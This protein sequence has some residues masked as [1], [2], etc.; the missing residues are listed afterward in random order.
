MASFKDAFEAVLLSPQLPSQKT[1]NSNCSN[2][3]SPG[4]I[5]FNFIS[6]R[7]PEKYLQTKRRSVFSKPYESVEE[8]ENFQ[9]PD[10]EKPKD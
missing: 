7:P 9:P 8:M 6:E 2:P 3:N 10:Y 5:P 1:T 4:T